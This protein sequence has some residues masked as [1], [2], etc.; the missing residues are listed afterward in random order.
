MFGEKIISSPSTNDAN[1]SSNAEELV[2][3]TLA[4]NLM[5]EQCETLP[6]PI[7]Y[8][9]SISNVKPAITHTASHRLL[10]RNMNSSHVSDVEWIY[11]LFSYEPGNIAHVIRHLPL[12]YQAHD[13]TGEP[14]P[15]YP[16]CPLPNIL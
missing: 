9:S 5:I 7:G 3:P 13:Y 12:W 16:A 2:I 6:C 11:V 1:V 8:I 10:L 15:M 4:L 14:S